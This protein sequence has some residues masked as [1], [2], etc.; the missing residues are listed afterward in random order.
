MQY[1]TRCSCGH[2]YT[3]NIYGPGNDRPRKA[4]WLATRPCPDCQ[5]AAE[6]AQAQQA[7]AQLPA[8]TGSEKQIAWAT[9]IRAEVFAQADA[10]TSDT[11]EICD[12]LA[13]QTSAKWWIDNGRSPIT[14]LQQ[15]H[16]IVAAQVAS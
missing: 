7:T 10:L 4:A 5:R 8:L 15:A 3:Y 1:P 9:K 14:L 6:L 16:T 2:T 13:T 11:T 12:W